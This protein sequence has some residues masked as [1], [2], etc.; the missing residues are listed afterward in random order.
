MAARVRRRRRRVLANST[1]AI[2][3]AVGLG[4][5][6]GRLLTGD[7]QT[8]PPPA[9]GPDRWTSCAVKDAQWAEARNRPTASPPAPP[10]RLGDDIA[11]VSVV[12]CDELTQQRSDGGTDRVGR[13]RRTDDVAALVAALRLPDEPRTTG[14]CFL[15]EV[16]PPWLAV[17][18]ADGRW[19]QPAV[20]VDSCHKP[21]QE[22]SQ[23]VQATPFTTV[24]TWTIEQLESAEAAAA[25]CGQKIKHVIALEGPANTVG[26]RS[27][28]REPFPAGREIRLC[29]YATSNSDWGTGEFVHGTV[30]P[31]NRRTAIERALRAAGAA[32]PCN[33][34]ASRFA[35]LQPVGGGLDIYVELDNCHRVLTYS[36]GTVFAQGNAALATLLDKS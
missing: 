26:R 28:L 21:R 32:K 4:I 31:A 29:V 23:A 14:G 12:I 7:D 3:L 30:L 20:P 24:S 27:V 33:T 16:V 18:D 13:E 2:A 25:R 35:M 15:M 36:G 17:I 1:L 9:A 6:G 11:P 8:P 19:M 10:L 5:G 34:R 22:F